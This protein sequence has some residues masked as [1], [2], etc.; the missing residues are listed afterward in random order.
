M[1]REQ[2]RAEKETRIREAAAQLFEEH[3]FQGTTTSAVAER[4]NVA[5]GTLFLY[6]RTKEELVGLVFKE[7]IRRA[8]D[9]AFANLEETSI[10]G[11]ASQIFGI[12]FNV[13][14]SAPDL[15]RV[16]IR[17]LLFPP[18]SVA[19]E[20]KVFDEE[21]VQRLAERISLRMDA[22]ELAREDAHFVA[23]VWSGHFIVALVAWLSGMLPNRK[24]AQSSLQAALELSVRGLLPR[25]AEGVVSLSPMTPEPAGKLAKTKRASAKTTA[26]KTPRRAAR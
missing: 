20:R 26:T 15:A 5:K 9:R 12:F 2:S 18:Q 14:A 21:L 13:Y 25:E 1:R 4:A 24:V 7:R 23:S 22:G 6:A 8:L 10:E 17:A 3:G 11:E 19:E 16:Y